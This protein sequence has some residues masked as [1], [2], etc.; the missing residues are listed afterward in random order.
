MMTLLALLP[1]MPAGIRMTAAMVAVVSLYSFWRGYRPRVE[2]SPEYIRYR[3]VGRRYTIFW[4]DVRGLDRYTPLN[5]NRTSQ[6]VYITRL[7][8]PPVDWRDMNANT[9]QLQD[10]P[11]LLETLRMYQQGSGAKRL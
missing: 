1:A 4:S 3:T 2:V 5:R 8:S 9:I 10:R 6:Y 7:D 11:G